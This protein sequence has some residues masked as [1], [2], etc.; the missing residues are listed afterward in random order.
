ML[1]ILVLPMGCGGTYGRFVYD[2]AVD[3]A[4]EQLTVLPD[5]HYYFS[6]P[7]AFP[8]AIIAVDSNYTLA[9]RLWKPIDMTE[10]QLKRWI[11]YPTRRA[12]YY[13]YT[14]GRRILDDRGNQLGVWYSLKDYRAF[15][16]VRMLDDTTVQI[17]TPIDETDRRRRSYGGRTFG[18]DD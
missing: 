3:E 13:P 2:E 4:F 12:L 5:H 10:A 6:G 16:T 9:S 18:G 14:Y 8:D 7:D 1:L 11:F 15:S 17:N